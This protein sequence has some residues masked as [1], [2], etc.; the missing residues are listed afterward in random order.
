MHSINVTC[1]ID[2]IN[3]I[4]VYIQQMRDG[5]SAA[6]IGLGIFS[7]ITQAFSRPTTDTQRVVATQ[8]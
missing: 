5:T 7:E 1:T 3:Y 4:Y 8:V 6:L 2:I